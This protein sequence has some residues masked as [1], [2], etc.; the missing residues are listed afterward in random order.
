MRKP[1]ISNT[2]TIY[3]GFSMRTIA[4]RCLVPKALFDGSAN[5]FKEFA[6]KQKTH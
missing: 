1:V 2:S 5:L 6:P 4:M 3:N